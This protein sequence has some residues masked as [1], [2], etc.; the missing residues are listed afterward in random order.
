MGVGRLNDE[1][2]AAWTIFVEVLSVITGILALWEFGARVDILPGPS[3]IQIG[4][5]VADDWPN[6]PDFPEPSPPE[7]PD[8]DED[9]ELA[10]PTG[11]EGSGGCDSTTLTW[12]PVE[13]AERYRIERDDGFSYTSTEA[14]HTFQPFPDGQ[15][16]EY[17]IVALA[18][19]VESEPSDPVSIG[20]CS[21]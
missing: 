14:Q 5:E 6:W 16:H 12:E 9:G 4:Q 10:T 13:G 20:P 21:F 17:R 8:P 15:T 2:G 19:P 18:F 11:V 7:F 3:P 1:R